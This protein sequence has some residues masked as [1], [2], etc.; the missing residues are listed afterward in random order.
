[1]LITVPV[2]RNLVGIIAGVSATCMLAAGVVFYVMKKR[3]STV[4][5]VDDDGDETN[6]NK[7]CVPEKAVTLD[8]F[9]SSFDLP[10]MNIDGSDPFLLDHDFPE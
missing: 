3:R 6:A 7:L 1:M 4:D 8:R 9:I 10:Q 2:C 5:N